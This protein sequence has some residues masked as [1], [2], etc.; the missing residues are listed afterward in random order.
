[1]HADENGGWSGALDGHGVWS[2][3]PFQARG[4]YVWRDNRFV[5]DH[6]AGTTPA[7]V[8]TDG[9]LAWAK[10]GWEVGG[11]AT[12]A[13]P[14][15]WAVL[16]LKNWPAGKLRGRFVYAV[17][18]RGAAHPGRLDAR[19]AASEWAGWNADSAQVRVE[20]PAFGPDT[21]AVAAWRRGGTL[22]LLGKP[23]GGGWTGR[24]HIERFP[25]D[26][27]P[28]GRASGL[29]G[30]LTTGDGTVAGRAGTLDVTGDLEGSDAK[31]FGID[32]ARWRLAEVKGRLLPT[33]DLDARARLENSFYLG[34][35]FDSAGTPVHLGNQ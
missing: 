15:R 29:K 7:G 13:N 21:F 28:D 10:Q 23:E 31:W 26:E 34:I 33:P 18:T 17:Q 35:H 30:L 9:R 22:Q 14:A 27:W 2:D 3:L 25:L 20:F 24:Y 16:G 8:M 4:H 19:L 5:I 32:A 12:D 11:D 1:F 6:L